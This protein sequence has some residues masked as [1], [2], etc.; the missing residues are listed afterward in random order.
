MLEIGGG[1][2]QATRDLAQTGAVI[3]CLEPGGALAAIARQNLERFA[4]VHVR[5]GTFEHLQNAR[6]SY[7]VIVSATAF[8]WIDPALSFAKASYLLH[9]GGWLALLTNAHAAGGTQRRIAE[10]VRD[11]HMK[12]APEVGDWSFLTSGEISRRA[13]AGGD[14]AAVWSRVERKLGEPPTVSELFEPPAVS[15][16]PWIAS[17]TRAGYLEML[18]SQSTYAL[19]DPALRE[20]LLESIGRL[21]DDQ[22]GGRVTKQYV[23]ILATA[24]TRGC[25]IGSVTV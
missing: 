13:R 4:N 23:T 15:T 20:Q 22:L 24:K 5:T 8:H 14:I 18:A 16:Y 17:Y 6:G 21:V 25:D 7:D 2:G 3:D 11:L 10:A 9:R 19:L 12:L 1:T